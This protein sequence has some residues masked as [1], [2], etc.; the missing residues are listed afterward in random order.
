MSKQICNLSR[1]F[2]AAKN[3]K[4]DTISQG[5]KADICCAL[6]G[7]L[8]SSLF[9]QLER[10]WLCRVP[11][12]PLHCERSCDRCS[13]VTHK[14]CSCTDICIYISIFVSVC[15]NRPRAL[16]LRLSVCFCFI[17]LKWQT[18]CAA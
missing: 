9:A 12:S 3:E 10:R 17:K 15:H 13:Q 8:H 1:H 6:F 14:S 18:Q 7:V 11:P 2:S 16:K 5:L 4:K